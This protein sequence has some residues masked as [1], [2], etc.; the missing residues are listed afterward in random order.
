MMVKKE[1]GFYLLFSEDGKRILG[2]FKTREEANVQML[3]HIKLKKITL[4]N[5]KKIN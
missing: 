2:K 4:N 1:R 3:R 5:K